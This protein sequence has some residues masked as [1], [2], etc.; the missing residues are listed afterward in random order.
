[1]VA[2]PGVAGYDS[3]I[4]E[5]EEGS[6]QAAGSDGEDFVVLLDDSDLSASAAPPYLPDPAGMDIL[7]VCGTLYPTC[8]LTH[9]IMGVCG[10]CRGDGEIFPTAVRRGW[11]T[12]LGIVT[13]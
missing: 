2:V 6:E 12:V 13:V 8:R 11:L 3:D 10:V 1:M 5:Q 9:G 4:T 7:L